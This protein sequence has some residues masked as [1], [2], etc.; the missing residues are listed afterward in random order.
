M[1][2]HYNNY[3]ILAENNITRKHIKHFGELNF[4]SYKINIRSRTNPSWIVY[5]TAHFHI[6]FLQRLSKSLLSC[7]NLVLVEVMHIGW[8]NQSLYLITSMRSR[9]QQLCPSLHCMLATGP[10]RT[11]SDFS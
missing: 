8:T 7:L 5:T 6:E 9:Q 4:L 1:N 2:E 11:N 10:R 3:W